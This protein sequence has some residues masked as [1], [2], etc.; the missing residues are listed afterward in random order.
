MPWGRAESFNERRRTTRPFYCSIFIFLFSADKVM[1]LVKKFN[2]LGPSE[3]A[4]DQKT[5]DEVKEKVAHNISMK[6]KTAPP[7]QKD[8][9]VKVPE[10]CN[11]DSK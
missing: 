5:L 6:N 3:E 10:P 7:A 1:S 9:E 8:E 11:Q 4:I 2:V